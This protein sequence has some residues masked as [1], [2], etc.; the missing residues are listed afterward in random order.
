MPADSVSR[1]E[2]DAFRA[3]VLD[4]LH[5]MRTELAR[6]RHEKT[7][8]EVRLERRRSILRQ[9]ADAIG[10]INWGTAKEVRRVLLG[11]V[12]PPEGMERI[13]GE[14]RRDAETP[15]SEGRIWGAIS[16][17]ALTPLPPG[18]GSHGPQWMID[19]LQ[20]RK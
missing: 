6:Q 3:E 20:R 10:P 13:V 2:F 11:E 16:T 18:G 4:Q 12:A 17:E 15:M 8:R 1:A 9:L 7:A 14:L 19:H 5:A